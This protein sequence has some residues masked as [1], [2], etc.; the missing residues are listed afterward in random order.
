M[1]KLFILPGVERRDLVGT[2]V[3]SERVLSRAI[4][5]GLSECVVV[6]RDRAGELFIAGTEP[7]IDKVTG[8]LV[9]AVH[10]LNE[11]AYTAPEPTPAPEPEKA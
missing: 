7:D 9:N 4:E 11:G 8:M 5:A 1:A 6:G 3:D 10:W 2:K